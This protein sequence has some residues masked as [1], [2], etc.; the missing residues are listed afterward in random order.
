MAE[1]ARSSAARGASATE[2][3]DV[4]RAADEVFRLMWGLPSGRDGSRIEGEVPFYG[5]KERWQTDETAFDSAYAARYS[6]RGPSV[7]DPRHLGIIGRGRYVR[8]LLEAIIEEDRRPPAQRA[9]AE[10]VVIALNNVIGWM[11][12]ERGSIK[13][14]IQPR[15]DLTRVWDAPKEFWLSSS[16]TGWAWEAFAQAINILKVHYD[17]VAEAR[18]HAADMERLVA[19]FLEGVDAD[20]DGNVAPAMME[21]GLLVAVEHWRRLTSGEAY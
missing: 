18:G 11:R 10:H 16:D 20:G 2:V 17:D 8:G 4:K 21:G 1:A 15:V 5:W 13:N 14:E 7:Q 3:D 6:G 19:R 12:M 9:H